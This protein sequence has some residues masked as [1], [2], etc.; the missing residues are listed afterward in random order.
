MRALI[1]ACVLLISFLSASGQ[2]LIKLGEFTSYEQDAQFLP[3]GIVVVH[4]AI[5]DS[6]T[7]VYKYRSGKLVRVKDELPSSVKHWSSFN[8]YNVDGSDQTDLSIYLNTSE[9]SYLPAHSKVKALAQIPAVAGGRVVK[10]VCYSVQPAEASERDNRS[11][12]LH[13][14]LMSRKAGPESTDTAY[15]K[16]ADVLVEEDVDFGA[17][18]LEPQPT[19]MFVAVYFADGGNHPTYSVAVY[20]VKPAVHKRK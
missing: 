5:E 16:I 1:G 3:G 8:W 12:N 4:N 19:G 11:P 14:L 17:L 6:Q 10:I 20:R 9:Q 18:L 15:T 2:S 13:L 7:K